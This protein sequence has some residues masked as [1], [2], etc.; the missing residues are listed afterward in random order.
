MRIIYF[1]T[2]IMTM[3]A[4]QSKAE[5]PY[6]EGIVPLPTVAKNAHIIMKNQQALIDR[7]RILG[8]SQLADEVQKALSVAFEPHPL[9]EIHLILSLIHI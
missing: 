9:I 3:F 8:G 2:I 6:E 4:L 1:L 7:L 5:V